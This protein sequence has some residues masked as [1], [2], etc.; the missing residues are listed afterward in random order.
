MQLSLRVW[1]CYLRAKAV[2][3]AQQQESMPVCPCTC[4]CAFY[5]REGLLSLRLENMAAASWRHACSSKWDINSAAGCKTQE[6]LCERKH[7]SVI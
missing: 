4:V 7:V 2:Q 6:W 5:W 3:G 1:N